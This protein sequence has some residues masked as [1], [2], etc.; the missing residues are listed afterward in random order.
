MKP[1]EK[2]IEDLRVARL[3]HDVVD[4][5]VSA[6]IPSKP[7][8]PTPLELNLVREHVQIGF[9]VLKGIS[10]P[11]PVAEIALQHHER[12]NGSGYPNGAGEA[13]ACVARII[14]V[15]DVQALLSRR[16]CRAAL[17]IDVALERDRP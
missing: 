14:A 10:F 13:I 9:D 4:I 11:W 17:G 3:L 7:C 15:A 16:P 2:A 12:M 6:E 5:S 1:G 8:A